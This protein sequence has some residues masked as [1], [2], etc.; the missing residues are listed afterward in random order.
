MKLLRFVR[1]MARWVPASERGR[2]VEAPICGEEK[3]WSVLG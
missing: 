2:S 1:E 3:R